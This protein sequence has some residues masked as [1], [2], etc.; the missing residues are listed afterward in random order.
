[1]QDANVTDLRGILLLKAVF[2]NYESKPRL[3]CAQK[4]CVA[5]LAGLQPSNYWAFHILSQIYTENHATFPIQIDVITV[6][7]CG[8]FWGTQYVLDKS[9][10]A[11]TPKGAQ[12]GGE[13]Q[14]DP[15]ARQS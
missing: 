10:V 9:I 2:S 12:D 14:M 15:V 6:Q 13:Q 11:A 5:A 4:P 8:N 3:S 7:I 1:M